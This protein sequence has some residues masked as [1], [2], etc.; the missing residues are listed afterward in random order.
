MPA[1]LLSFELPCMQRAR[2][3]SRLLSL[4]HF[5][6]NP[7]GNSAESD[8]M[9]AAQREKK[10]RSLLNINCVKSEARER[11]GKWPASH[12]HH[13]QDRRRKEAE[14]IR[15]VSPEAEAASKW[16]GGTLFLFSLVCVYKSFF[17]FIFQRGRTSRTQDGC[18]CCFTWYLFQPFDHF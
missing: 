1:F 14:L 17:V 12:R 9:A 10:R 2:L 13:F 3:S 18:C 11:W 4:F 8:I 7:W 15:Q 6:L 5:L 16:D